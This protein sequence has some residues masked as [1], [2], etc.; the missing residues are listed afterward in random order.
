LAE[1]KNAVGRYL[2]GVHGHASKYIV[3]FNSRA[4][5]PKP[6]LNSTGKQY[7]TTAKVHNAR[8]F[9]KALIGKRS[10]PNKAFTSGL[11]RRKQHLR[12]CT[13]SQRF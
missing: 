10:K 2:R 6:T 9:S 13:K 4:G 5:R 1:H 3:S 7:V 12:P 8:M 11:R